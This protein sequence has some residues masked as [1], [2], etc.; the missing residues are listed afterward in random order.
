VPV[1]VEVV[2]EQVTNI[3]MGTELDAV[4]EFEELATLAEH[5][6]TAITLLD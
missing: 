2:L 4:N 3:S 5:A 1:V 6:P